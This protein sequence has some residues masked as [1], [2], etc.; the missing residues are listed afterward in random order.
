MF[1]QNDA[2]E[3]IRTAIQSEKEKETQAKQKAV[4]VPDDL[5]EEEEDLEAV[6]PVAKRQMQGLSS[7]DVRSK[8]PNATYQ[9]RGERRNL[10]DRKG[11]GKQREEG[12]R[13]RTSDD[14]ADEELPSFPT[15]RGVKR[16]RAT[17][18]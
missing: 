4:P 14:D 1:S 12:K 11:K 13:A 8:Y 5:E 2:Q 3:S 6:K 7:P 15:S 18:H 9:P 16:S 10:E 17:R